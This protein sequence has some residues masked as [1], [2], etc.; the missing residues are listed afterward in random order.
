[1]VSLQPSTKILISILVG[2]I[3]A[4]CLIAAWALIPFPDIILFPLK[5]LGLAGDTLRWTVII[6]DL[7]ANI[8]MLLLPAMILR[9]MGLARI[10]NHTALAILA[11]YLSSS[12]IGGAPMWPTS[13]MQLVLNLLPYTALCI[14]VW[15]LTKFGN[16][17]PN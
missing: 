12:I 4:P 8:L 5:S 9:S 16:H 1:M 14:C 2:V 17:T 15:I 11:F 13:F 6:A 10:V 7:M 3:S